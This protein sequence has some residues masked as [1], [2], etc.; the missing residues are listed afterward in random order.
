[1]FDTICDLVKKERTIDIEE[2][3]PCDIGM[4]IENT[5]HK[6]TIVMRTASTGKFEVMELYPN[7]GMDQCWTSRIIGHKVQLMP[8]GFRI[9]LVVT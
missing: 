4:I 3:K 9:T 8:K 1:M 5:T 7:P 2:M 6:G